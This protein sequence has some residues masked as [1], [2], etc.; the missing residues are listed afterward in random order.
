MQEGAMVQ[1]VLRLVEEEKV[2]TIQTEDGEVLIEIESLARAL[3]AEQRRLCKERAKRRGK[4]STESDSGE[5]DLEEEDLEEEDLE[6][7]EE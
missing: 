1:T 2:D 3:R 4:N 5:E 7:S 6:E